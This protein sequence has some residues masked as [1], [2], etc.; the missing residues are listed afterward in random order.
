MSRSL[1]RPS[2]SPPRTSSSVALTKDPM[3]TSVS[4]GCS[5]WPSHVPL[6]ASLSLVGDSALRTCLA[7]ALAGASR[8]SAPSTLRTSGSKGVGR[9]R[10]VV[11]GDG[12]PA[13]RGPARGTSPAMRVALA[14]LLLAVTAPAAA[15]Q[16][17]DFAAG[18]HQVGLEFDRAG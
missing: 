18:L 1:A 8:A 7:K 2:A 6:T 15:A 12:L 5:A 10:G 3:T 9:R 13:R 4:I 11:M 14:L 16:Q 17:A